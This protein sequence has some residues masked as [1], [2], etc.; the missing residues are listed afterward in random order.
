MGTTRP[1][2]AGGEEQRP[3][4][5]QRLRRFGYTA[6]PGSG[7]HDRLVP[8]YSRP[9]PGLWAALGVSPA[10]AGRVTRWSP[11]GGPLLVALLAGLLRFWNL[12]TPKA[13][14]LD[15]TYYAKHA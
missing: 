8:P 14:L 11:W 4:W 1:C 15:E 13:V 3:S 10:G 12:G 5:Q 6:G 2:Q 9:G 7:V